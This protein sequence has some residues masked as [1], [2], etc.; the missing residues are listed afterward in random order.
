MTVSA[1]WRTVT[2]GLFLSPT[3]KDFLV[4]VR[5]ARNEELEGVLALVQAFYDEDGFTT[6]AD[7]LIRH[8]RI[9]LESTAARVA[10]AER[11]GQ[12]IATAITTT[13]FGLESGFIAE[14]EDL[15]VV[16]TSRRHGVAEWL[17]EDSAAWARAQGCHF[18]EVVIAPNG[19]DVAHLDE[20]YTARGFRDDGRRLL[21]RALS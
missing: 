17:I 7:D 14:L 13:S 21:S 12:L 4:E 2:T 5:E 18:L 1:G 8:L 15:Y 10:V 3:C 20:Y 11:H 19:H 9:L 6:S 16:P